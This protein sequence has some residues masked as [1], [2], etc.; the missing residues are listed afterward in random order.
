MPVDVRHEAQPPVVA[1]VHRRVEDQHRHRLR[2]AQRSVRARVDRGPQR[3]GRAL[4]AAGE[5]ERGERERLAEPDAAVAEVAPAACE[6]R[7]RRRIVQVHVVHV[8]HHQLDAAERVV[9]AGALA[10][11]HRAPGERPA[12][13]LA[14]HLATDRAADELHVLAGEPPRVVRELRVELL[15]RDRARHVPVRVDLDRLHRVD[16]HRRAADRAAD[17]HRH[18]QR[19]APRLDRPQPVLRDVHR[20]PAA[21]RRRADP[22]QPLE[23]QLDLPHPR[24]GG[25]LQRGE[26][27]GPEHAVG[28]EPVAG[29]ESAQRVRGRRVE[30]T[31]RRRRVR[32]ELALVAQPRAQRVDARPRVAGHDLAPG[33]GQRRQRH[34]RGTGRAPPP[35]GQ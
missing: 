12:Q 14:P 28:I 9:R 13:R 26:R 31:R 24:G 25:H 7:L 17:D 10:Q 15:R 32:L 34:G 29:L 23:R 19:D 2:D 16:E 18:R 27:R 22:A 21:L 5:H 4:G 1:D 8:R 6:E 11:A 35:F 3:L 33:R 20:D 30:A